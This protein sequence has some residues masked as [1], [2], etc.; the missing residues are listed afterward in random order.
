M[1][2]IAVLSD[3][4][5]NGWNSGDPYT[6][7]LVETLKTG[8]DAIWHG[9]DVVSSDVL[10]ALEAVAPLTVVKGNCDSFLGRPLPHAVVETVEGV[11][12][13]MTHGWDL[14]LEHP[15]TVVQRFPPDVRLII[16]GHT[17]RRRQEDY[18]RPDG[19]VVTLLNPGS[20]SSPRGGETPGMA[21]LVIDGEGFQYRT[22]S[23]E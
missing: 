18:T 7:K 21:E 1:Q 14:P 6:V 11:R 16:H 5:W 17:H 15:P 12:I 22:I 4:H 9:G 19:S 23:F 10:D 13:A 2:R 20:V 8:F 3:T